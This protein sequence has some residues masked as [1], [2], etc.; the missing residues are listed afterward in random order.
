MDL[1]NANRERFQTNIIQQIYDFGKRSIRNICVQAPTG[2]GKT[3]ISA[4]LAKGTVSKGRHVLVITPRRRIT[5]QM[6]DTFSRYG[7]NPSY[8]M[9]GMPY[10]RNSPVQVACTA[11]LWLRYKRAKGLIDSD[12][13]KELDLQYGLDP[14]EAALPPADVV[15]VDEC[16]IGNINWLKTV[17]PK[18]VFIGYSATPIKGN[19]DGLGSQYDALVRGPSINEMVEAGIL[20]PAH[21][22]NSRGLVL[23]DDMADTPKLIGRVVEQWQ[24]H[25]LDLKTVF[26]AKNVGH[27]I[28]LCE[29]FN[30]AGIPAEHID[31]DISDEPGEDGVSP[32]DRIYARLASGEIKVLCNFGIAVEGVDIPEIECVALARP[33]KQQVMNLI[34]YLQAIGRGRRPSGDKTC[35]KVLDYTKTV[36]KLKHPDSDWDWDLEETP[37]SATEKLKRLRKAKEEEDAVATEALYKCV[38]GTEYP[39]SAR[40]CP[41][42]GTP[43]PPRIHVLE[44][45]PV[46]LVAETS[47]EMAKVTWTRELAMDLYAQVIG[48]HKSKGHENWKQ[49]TKAFCDKKIPNEFQVVWGYLDYIRS[50]KPDAATVKLINNDLKSFLF[51][52]GVIRKKVA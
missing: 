11:T 51:K 15:H 42:C 19:G 9:A 49:R 39:V 13:H 8:M 1:I 43:M 38:C 37:K 29:Q 16:H 28:H 27:S 26:F 45:I 22:V 10:D 20:L 36:E 32:R 24:E 4:R 7:L 52:K 17:Y 34:T 6:Y 23:P 14:M 21:V 30:R 2:A 33:N 44:E 18:A 25:C 46:Q 48:Y 41:K 50:K 31:S 47:R 40:K 5:K 12:S 3:H 35:V